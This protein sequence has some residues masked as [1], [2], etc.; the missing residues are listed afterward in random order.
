MQDAVL[1]VRQGHPQPTTTDGGDHP[2]ECA[3]DDADLGAGFDPPAYPV[4]WMLDL[5]VPGSGFHVEKGR[6]HGGNGAIR[7]RLASRTLRP[8][9]LQV[10]LH[11]CSVCSN[12]VT[13]RPPDSD[14]FA[15]T[16]R[17]LKTSPPA[18]LVAA[19]RATASGETLLAPTIIRRFLDEFTRRPHGGDVPPAVAALTERERHVLV[20]V[21]RG[22]SNAE[23]AR[24]LVV[25]EGTVKSHLNRLFAKL[26]VRDRVQAVVLAYE[27]G[28]VRPGTPEPRDACGAGTTDSCS[29][30]H[31]LTVATRVLRSR[32]STDT[33]KPVGGLARDSRQRPVSAAIAAVPECEVGLGWREADQR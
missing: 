25:S 23:V 21:A 29:T 32:L 12:P 20:L 8:L 15:A 19:V 11:Q 9:V 31:P 27:S 2:A 18:Q 13:L 24:E 33:A 6:H 7:R 5:L 22:L 3:A 10:G 14:L 16:Q 4:T 1:P 26:G 30:A 17:E 28:L